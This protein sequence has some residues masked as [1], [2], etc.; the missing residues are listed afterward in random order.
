MS[1]DV[2]T[3]LRQSPEKDET[4]LALAGVTGRTVWLKVPA[5]NLET[6]ESHWWDLFSGACFERQRKVLEITLEPYGI[7]WLKA[8]TESR[9]ANHVDLLHPA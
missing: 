9:E 1:P 4:I 8:C 3:V 6:D 5:Q 2:F 7:L